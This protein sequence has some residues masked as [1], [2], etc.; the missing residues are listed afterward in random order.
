MRYETMKNAVTLALAGRS[1]DFSR[2]VTTSRWSSSGHD[3][4]IYGSEFTGRLD[5]NQYT[6][7]ISVSDVLLEVQSPIRYRDKRMISSGALNSKTAKAVF[8]FTSSLAGRST[9]FSRCMPI[10]HNG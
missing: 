1:T 5:F 3:K 2:C 4:S 6:R 7:E 9:D 8:F 10:T